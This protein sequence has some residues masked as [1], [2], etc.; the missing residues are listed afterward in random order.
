MKVLTSWGCVRIKSDNSK[1]KINPVPTTKEVYHPCW[2]CTSNRELASLPVTPPTLPNRSD[3]HFVSTPSRLRPVQQSHM[4]SARGRHRC[5]GDWSLHMYG[6]C[7][8]RK[9]TQSYA[10]MIRHRAS[11]RSQQV[12]ALMLI[13]HGFLVAA[14][15]CT[16]LLCLVHGVGDQRLWETFISHFRGSISS[17]EKWSQ[18]HLI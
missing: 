10:Y 6:E 5:C 17:S 18:Q 9:T 16:L 13:P 11:R 4:H 12:S 2:V 7:F 14:A 3:F 15:L 1:K 8:L